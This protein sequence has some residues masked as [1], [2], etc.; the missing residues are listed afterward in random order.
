MRV[1]KSVQTVQIA[2]PARP[3]R[4]LAWIS[5]FKAR[6][7][8]GEAPIGSKEGYIARQAPATMHLDSLHSWCESACKCSLH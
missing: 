1:A 5:G 4:G 3:L 8:P 2:N 7:G 6:S